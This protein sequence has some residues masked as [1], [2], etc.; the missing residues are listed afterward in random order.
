MLS[1]VRNLPLQHAYVQA[2]L[3]EMQAALEEERALIGGSSYFD[4]QKEAWTIKGIRKR[5]ILAIGLMICQQMTGTNAINYYAPTI[6]SNLGVT[7]TAQSLFATG[8]Y[9]ICKVVGCAAFIVFLADSVGRR[10]SLMVSSGW[11]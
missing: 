10:K 1:R 6:F 7:G 5:T 11:I 3:R 9:G 8:V 2:E 4:L